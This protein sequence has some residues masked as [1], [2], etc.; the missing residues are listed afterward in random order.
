MLGFTIFVA[1]SYEIAALRAQAHQAF[2]MAVS[3][4]KGNRDSGLYDPAH[5]KLDPHLTDAARQILF[6]RINIANGHGHL[7]PEM[8]QSGSRTAAIVTYCSAP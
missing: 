3:Q 6:R 8:N 1:L 5:F 2:C 7:Y 4:R